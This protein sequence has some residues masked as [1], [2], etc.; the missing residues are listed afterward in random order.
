MTNFNRSEVL[1]LISDLYKTLM[2]L[3][4]EVIILMNGQTQSLKAFGMN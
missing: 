3:D 1:S 4:Q 2:E